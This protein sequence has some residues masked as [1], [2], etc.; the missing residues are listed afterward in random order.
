M[1]NKKTILLTGASKGIGLDITQR[2]INKQYNLIVCSRTISK[3]LDKILSK[4]NLIKHYKV[5]LSSSES[6]DQF[7]NNIKDINFYGLVNNAGYAKEGIL[8]TMPEIEIENMININLK[9]TIMLSRFFSRNIIKHKTTG[10]IV[11]ISS[12][13]SDRGFNG[14]S[15]Y[16][17]T[18]A[19][20]NGLTLSLARELGRTGTT[21]NA[22]LP[23]FIETDMSSGLNSKQL[24]QILRR[25]P[26]GKLAEKSEISSL[27]E[28]LLSENASSIT[29]QL[30]KI[31][32]GNTV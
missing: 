24:S 31:D 11:N 1:D 9:S 4:E 2:L 19:A 16:S 22:I 30:I 8:A 3:E 5:D 7:L 32:G 6:I 14:L 17:A 27:V 28:Y 20:L 18:K 29:G 15:V 13:I 26:I 10:R 25:T 23:G 21:V 12:I